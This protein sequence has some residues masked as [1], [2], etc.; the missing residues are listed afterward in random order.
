VGTNRIQ[1]TVTDSRGYFITN[2]SNSTTFKVFRNTTQIGS[3]NTNTSQGWSS[4]TQSFTIA[5]LRDNGTANY[6]TNRQHAF[7]T[8]GDGLTD[9]ESKLLYECVDRYQKTLGRAV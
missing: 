1:G 4:L 6:F 8:L 2:R 9:A 7:A 3:T 5:A